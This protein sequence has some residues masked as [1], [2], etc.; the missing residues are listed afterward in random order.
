MKVEITN[1]EKILFPKD[2]ITKADLIKYY[3]V[4]AKQIIPLIKDRPIS[5]M[6][7]PDGIKKGGFVQKKVSE[8]FPNWIKT[9]SIARKGKTS[10]KMLV[11]ND[12][13]TL[14]YLAN[15]ACITPHIWL[16]KK[17]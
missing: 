2:K 17:R 14:K 15:Q 7:Y 6:R 12:K 10:I 16:S 3:E 1:P 9:K 4:A 13:D 5:M 8:Y 11:C